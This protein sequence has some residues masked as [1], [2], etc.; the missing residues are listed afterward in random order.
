VD[1]GSQATSVNAASEGF[2]KEGTLQIT[3][4]KEQDKSSYLARALP[5]LPLRTT[6]QHRE[7]LLLTFCTCGKK[8][9]DS[10]ICPSRGKSWSQNPKPSL[11]PEVNLPQLLPTSYHWRGVS[12]STG[13]PVQGGRWLSQ[14]SGHSTSLER[15]LPCPLHH[16][17]GISSSVHDAPPLSSPSYQNP[18]LALKNHSGQHL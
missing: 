9:R 14:G 12:C 16:H 10:Q 2:R 11:C 7:R 6:L 17:L 4:H 13:G 5:T 3:G 1:R 18:F 15:V 8:F